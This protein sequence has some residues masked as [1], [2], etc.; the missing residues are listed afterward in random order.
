MYSHLSLWTEYYHAEAFSFDKL[1]D[2]QRTDF[3]EQALDFFPGM[4]F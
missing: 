3:I 1:L 4:A 2:M